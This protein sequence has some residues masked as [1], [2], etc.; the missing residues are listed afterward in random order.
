MDCE[1]TRISGT[2]LFFSRVRIPFQTVINLHVFNVV[3]LCRSAN[4]AGQYLSIQ[5]GSGNVELRKLA[6]GEEVAQTVRSQ[7]SIAI[8]VSPQFVYTRAEGN[9]LC[10]VCDY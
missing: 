4:Y 10:F 1:T 5:E 9:M 3:H 6:L 7:Y 2:K 8:L